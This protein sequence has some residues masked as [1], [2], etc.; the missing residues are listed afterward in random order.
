MAIGS[1]R[2]NSWTWFMRTSAANT[3]TRTLYMYSRCLWIHHGGPVSV[4]RA[5]FALHFSLEENNSHRIDI[6]SIDARNAHRIYC[7]NFWLES[8][9]AAAQRIP[10]SSSFARH[11]FLWNF[12]HLNCSVRFSFRIQCPLFRFR[13]FRRSLPRWHR[14]S[15]Q[16]D[17]CRAILVILVSALL[18]HTNNGDKWYMNF[19]WLVLVV[20][21]RPSTARR[22]LVESPHVK[23]NK[24]L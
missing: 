23:Q 5:A 9:V 12:W 16:M 19:E 21:R 18:L 7:S 24:A 20:A 10:A 4:T 15:I 1:E 3:H 14:L 8:A 6:E 17:C 2:V 11:N 13:F 22:H